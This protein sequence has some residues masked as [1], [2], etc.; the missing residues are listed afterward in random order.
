[1][2][3][4]TRCGFENEDSDT[5]CGSCAGFLE[6]EGQ[7]VAEE[8]P[9]PEP[10]P[11]PEPAIEHVGLI[12]RVKEAIGL[13]DDTGA[14]PDGPSAEPATEAEPAVAAAEPAPTAPA[15]APAPAQPA[16]VAAPVATAAT[17]APT[18]PPASPATGAA[19][20]PGGP[21]PP[22]TG[23]APVTERTAMAERA[24]PAPTAAPTPPAPTQSAPPERT[25]AA[26]AAAAAAPPQGAAPESRAGETPAPGMGAPGAPAA[27]SAPAAMGTAPAASAPPPS[28]T[29]PPPPPPQPAAPER[30][31]PTAPTPAQPAAPVR[32]APT[33]A[34]PAQPLA[35]E[36][37]AP[38]APAATPAAAAPSPATA[39]VQPEAV[40]PSAVKTRPAVKKAAPTRVINP[41]DKIC[42][43][44]GEGNDPVRRF[45]RRCGASLNEAVVFSLSWYKR[46]WRRL[47]HRK[48]RVA[49]ERPRN[50]RRAIGGA[51]PG[52]LTSWVTRI[53]ALAIIVFVVLTF[54]GPAKKPIR[55]RLSTWYHDVANV[56]HPTY[57]QIHPITASAST[58]APGHPPALLI[59]GVSNTSWESNGK[60]AGQVVI[61]RL[62]KAA[63]IDKIGF[64]IG[65][66]DS[67]QAYLTEPRPDQIR[68]SFNGTKPYQKTITLK[69]TGAFQ[70]FGVSA[71]ETTA[72]SVTILSVYPSGQGHDV[73]ITEVE[74]FSKSR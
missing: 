3:V 40:K 32:P 8:V 34:I 70:T 69:D 19:G 26:P 38:S 18:A 29:A 60:G 63:D 37:P 20:P 62:A 66:T 47:T 48:Q 14:S 15:P 9:E 73:S 39:P 5:F 7:K 31:I 35:Q 42:G 45:C 54:V 43:Q 68:V 11:E 2:I 23:A 25:A 46:A 67:P 6:W 17:G 65:D 12:E 1:M 36:R 49:G 56:I 10:E 22:A 64:L 59:D 21:T 28:A 58:S 13:G 50:R 41:G 72:F 33:A 74:I 61:I 53:I 52:W 24:T 55:H 71:K 4:C 44:C 27:A 16:P 30:P 57:N 51:G